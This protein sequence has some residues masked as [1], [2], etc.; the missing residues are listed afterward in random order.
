MRRPWYNGFAEVCA[1][2]N[3]VPAMASEEIE[4]VRAL[5]SSQPRPQGW[6]ERRRRLD[7]VGIYLAGG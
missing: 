6:S 3:G 7:E 5:L 1:E 4:A 2:R